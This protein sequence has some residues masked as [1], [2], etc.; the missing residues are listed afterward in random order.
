MLDPGILRVGLDPLE[1]GLGAD[2]LDLELGDEDGQVARR[3][4]D[5]RDRAL[6][7]Q[8][9]K[10]REVLDIALV[11]EHDAGQLLAP[12]V[13]QERLASRLQ[14]FGRDAGGGPH[15]GSLSCCARVAL[16]NRLARGFVG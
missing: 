13:L 7:R 14:L 8:K 9:R 10:A 2:P 6:C 12:D 15:E 11:E 16:R 3:A 4:R 5:D 1:L